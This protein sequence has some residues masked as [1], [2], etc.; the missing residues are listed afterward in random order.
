MGTF[1]GLILFSLYIGGNASFSLLPQAV[2]DS[3]QEYTTSP[4]VQIKITDIVPGVSL[5]GTWRGLW[6][7]HTRSGR[8]SS[9]FLF[10]NLSYK[11]K[12][13]PISFTIGRQFTYLYFGGLLDGASGVLRLHGWKAKVLYGKMAPDIFSP[14]ESF[15]DTSSATLL[16]ALISSPLLFKHT[17]LKA[18]YFQKKSG[19]SLQTPIWASIEY[20]FRMNLRMEVA[21]D[22]KD[23]RLER[24]SA[25]GYGRLMGTT[26]L[27]GVRYRD[28]SDV[29]NLWK[30]KES[31][32]EEEESAK[33]KMTRIEASL[34]YSLTPV[35]VSLGTWVAL[36]G[37]TY[38]T[39]WVR[40]RYQWIDY[41]GWIGKEPQGWQKGSSLSLY[42]PLNGNTRVYI[43]GRLIDEPRTP[44]VWVESLRAGLRFLLPHNAKLRTELRIWQNIEVDRE[45][46]GFINLSVPFNWRV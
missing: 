13:S 21:Y 17:I 20:Y 40:A 41:F 22:T 29:I 11:T 30:I 19:D 7:D 39:Y 2:T 24:F 28:L 38:N 26:W 16:G 46:Q 23:S 9:R 18:G 27:L 45:I 8:A 1:I 35:M 32:E 5:N 3:T 12:D 36:G 15:W 10:A 42:Y 14:I 37:E 33:E 44:D 25:V 43:S 31:E 34:R 4:R 6:N